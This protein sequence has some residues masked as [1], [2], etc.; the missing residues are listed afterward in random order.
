V[1]KIKH[2]FEDPLLYVAAI[3]LLSFLLIGLSKSPELIPIFMIPVYFMMPKFNLKSWI[4]KKL[5]EI[6]EE[7]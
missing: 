2:R 3:P 5:R 4:Q 6:L 7:T 1:T